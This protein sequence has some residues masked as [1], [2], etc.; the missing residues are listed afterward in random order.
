MKTINAFIR[1]VFVALAMMANAVSYAEDTPT[2]LDVVS[3]PEGAQVFVDN[4]ARGVAPVSIYDLKPGK[5]LV[6]VEAPSYVAHNEYVELSSGGYTQMACALEAE[7]ALILIRSQP[8]G[9]DV[10]YNGVSIGETP[11]LITTF[12]TGKTYPVE[13]SLT[14]YRAKKIN[15]VPEGRKPLVRDEA[16]VLDSGIVNC[17]SEPS[18][19]TV[20]VNGTERGVTPVKIEN[21][22]K[23]LATITMKLAGYQ[24]ESR[25]LRL[26]PGEEQALSLKL[27]GKPACLKVV[28]TPENARVF[29][30]G[31][32]QGKTPVTIS[33]L[34]AGSHEIRIELAGHGE[35]TRKIEV[36]NGQELTEEFT[37]SSVLGR[38]EIIT[39]PAGA[40]ISLDGKAIGTTRS[41][42]GDSQKS[43][44]LLVN[45]V[46]AGTHS[47]LA[48]VDGYQDVLRR[49]TVTSG[50]P[51][52]IVI[53]L[54]SIFIPDTK[55][56]TAT[57]VRPYVG[58]L[59]SNGPE[60]LVLETK[61]GIRQTFRPEDI[62]KVEPINH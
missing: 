59:I 11:L 43:Q 61:P 52:T 22:P 19:A 62:R 47:I 6:H 51:A 31:D 55:V 54:R 34:A 46:Q 15:L 7:R 33:T 38:L 57:G 44:V 26:A 32:Y 18:G 41:Q 42:G 29:V 28:S 58:V 3:H 4:V 48:H 56:E 35:L 16:L 25:E 37:L 10:R 30:D 27:K 5:H 14:G 50:K 12:A 13:L 39:I 8:S 40:K 23:G 20:I 9:A 49:V 36:A 53:K 60:G 21:V 2:R 24:D 1:T 45:N 17:S